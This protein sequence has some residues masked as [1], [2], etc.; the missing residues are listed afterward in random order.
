LYD[1][2][3]ARALS[4]RDFD[5][6]Y[7]IVTARGAVKH[8]H[9]F[10]RVFE[11]IEGRPILCGAVQDVT[12]SKIAEDALRASARNL[13]LIVNTIPALAW[14]ARSDGVAEFFNQ[15]YLDYVGLSAEQARNWGWTAAVHPDDLNDVEATWR[16]IIASGESGEAEARLRRHDGECR[17][18]LFRMS[19]LRDE[20]G[21][22]LKWYGINTDIDDRKRAEELRL[23]ERVNERTRIARELHDTLLQ[24]FQGLLMK[25]SALKYLI[26]DRPSEA[27]EKLDRMVVETRQ[28]V[29]EGRDAVLELRSSAATANDLARAITHLGESL[30]T[31]ADSPEFC[32]TVEGKSLELPPFVCD[33]VY[34][35]AAE[36]MR[37]ACRHASAKRIEVEIRY[38]NGG[39]RLRVRD[40]G[41]GIDPDILEAGARI[42]HHGLPGMRERAKRI[43]GKL[44]VWSEPASGTRIAITIPAAVAYGKASSSASTW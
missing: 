43:G 30:A 44:A 6:I 18:F 23:E 29:T 8:I 1:A 12:E 25:F 2:E 14:S 38:D 10:A 9:V 32:T 27:E 7:R 36:A 40:Y 33:E 21:N 31:D 5:L 20:N 37:N 42:G 19:P 16:S 24:S 11:L 15:H 26:R 3:K 34:R 41:K 39:F 28:A 35:I 13:K 17:W 4:G 22:I